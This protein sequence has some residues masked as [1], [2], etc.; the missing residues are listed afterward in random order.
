MF[1]VLKS[2]WEAAWRFRWWLVGFIS[3][4]ILSMALSA[5]FIWQTIRDDPRTF[6]KDWSIDWVPA[7]ATFA[8]AVA[9]LQQVSLASRGQQMESRGQQMEFAPVLKI[10]LKILKIKD[11]V[12]KETKPADNWYREP[13]TDNELDWQR[14][15]GA[16]IE[17]L[18]LSITNQQDQATGAAQKIEVV[19]SLALPIDSFDFTYPV[20]HLEPGKTDEHVLVNMTG[21]NWSSAMITA[22]EF[23]DESGDRYTKTHG[24]GHLSRDLNGD[25]AQHYVTIE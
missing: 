14:A 3:A 7:L 12:L 11:D 21:L 13:F 6:L 23:L 15:R 5:E 24:L 25:W 17:G 19:V 22:I 2:F 20:G 16:D 1:Q 18:V 8:V 4:V 10:E 9:V